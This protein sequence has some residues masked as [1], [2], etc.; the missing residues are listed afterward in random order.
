VET[1]AL[2]AAKAALLGR[3]WRGGV[4]PTDYARVLTALYTL[5][6]DGASAEH[7]EACAQGDAAAAAG[8]L[9]AWRSGAPIEWGVAWN[10]RH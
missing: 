7:L 2:Q 3:Y 1:S 8:V 4:T 9:T 6:A 5:H 10:S